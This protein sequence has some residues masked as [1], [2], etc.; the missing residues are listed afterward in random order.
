VAWR[1]I[2]VLLIGWGSYVI[3]DRK[4]VAR[5]SVALHRKLYGWV[6]SAY[7]KRPSRIRW[8]VLAPMIGVII[9]IV[10]MVLLF[11]GPRT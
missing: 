1:L 5:I 4:R 10:G 2:G 6:P 3:L 7:M 9:I 11:V 8:R